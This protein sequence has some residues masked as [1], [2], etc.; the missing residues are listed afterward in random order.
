MTE[1]LPF[2][3][4]FEAN[5]CLIQPN[6][7]LTPP[8]VSGFQ[9][10]SATFEKP[11]MMDKCES[12][13]QIA[14][15]QWAGRRK[16]MELLSRDKILKVMAVTRFHFIAGMPTAG[17]ELLTEILNQNPRFVARSD[18]LAEP[19]YAEMAGQMNNP[20]SVISKLDRD[21]RN[22]LLRGSLDTTYHSRPLASVVFDNNPDW[23][24]HTYTLSSMMP[25]S[26]FIF[27]VR[28]P[29]SIAASLSRE[30]GGAKT[31]ASLMEDQGEIGEP[32]QQLHAILSGPNAERVILI[33]RTRFLIDP[34]SVLD[35]LYRFLRE[36]KFEHDTTLIEPEGA[37][38][39]NIEPR[40]LR[41]IV[42]LAAPTRN[43][44]GLETQL[45]VWRRLRNSDAVMVLAET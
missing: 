38:A 13:W 2:R 20:E 39:D 32:L 33:D 36:E 14:K 25:L 37:V 5:G 34:V 15:K 23:M 44:G 28:D 42:S 35:V 11:T 40:G 19:L 4:I 9:V 7:W 29:A 30:S 3:Q 12:V 8:I 31:P 26:R 43:R 10:F 27:M 6:K 45:P 41:R 21:S 1:D 17:A 24:K 16:A 18:T 22:A